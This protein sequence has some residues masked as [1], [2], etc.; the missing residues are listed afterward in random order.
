MPRNKKGGKKAK[1]KGNKHEHQ[2]NVLE[3]I[4]TLYNDQQFA[5]LTINKGDCRFEGLFMDGIVRT[6]HVPGSFRKKV[7]FKVGDFVVSSPRPF[8]KNKADIEMK[9]SESIIPEIKKKYHFGENNKVDDT[10]CDNYQD[11]TVEFT[12]I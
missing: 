6:C 2:Q 1:S 11:D 8:Q 5:E 3:K 12:D 10:N 9:I 4:P 7:W